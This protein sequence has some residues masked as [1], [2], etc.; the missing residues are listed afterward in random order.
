MLHQLA[1]A[2][3]KGDVPKVVD[4]D[5][6]RREIIEAVWRI[7]VRDGVEAA[8]LRR[9]ADEAGLAIGSVRHY[10]SSHEELL[11][12]AAQA[13]VDRLTE[14]LETHV[15]RA[16]TTDRRS[17]VTD[18]FEELLPLDGRRRDEVAVWFAFLAAARTNPALSE[19]A[20]E[21]HRGTRKLARIFLSR[22]P[23][24][25]DETEVEYLCAVID[26]LAM[27]GV[28]QPRLLRPK[29]IRAVLAQHLDGVQARAD[30]A[31]PD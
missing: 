14:R 28:L 2:C 26:G 8:S 25:A 9:V 23:L 7:V 1:R 6:R 27:T 22:T 20:R 19:Q 30:A 3:Y 5:A 4:A 31:R 12:A 13:M 15:A 11:V 29:A 18:L 21:L 24:G 10:F 16:S 17:L